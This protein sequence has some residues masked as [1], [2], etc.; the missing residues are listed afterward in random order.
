MA[1]KYYNKLFK[2][3]CIADMS[4]YKTAQIGLRW[5]TQKEVFSGDG[6]F[7]CGNQACKVPNTLS[8]SP[9]I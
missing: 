3:Y 6:Q 8:R 9:P 7:L 4:R 2:E 1:V 5:R